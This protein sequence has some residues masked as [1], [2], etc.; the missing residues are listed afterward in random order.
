[1][2]TGDEVGSALSPRVRPEIERHDASTHPSHAVQ[3]INQHHHTSV[4]CASSPSSSPSSASC[5]SSPEPLRANRGGMTKSVS[6][7]HQRTHPNTSPSNSRHTFFR[8]SSS[9]LPAARS[10]SFSDPDAAPEAA[11]LSAA[12]DGFESD[13]ESEEP[14]V[15]HI[16][17][18][19]LTSSRCLARSA[20]SSSF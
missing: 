7:T 2:R 17:L 20:A 4:P 16:L 13:S 5:P 9:F 3:T 11:S 6:Q 10:P 8:F 1:M 18:R 19:L 14:T 15:R 12:A